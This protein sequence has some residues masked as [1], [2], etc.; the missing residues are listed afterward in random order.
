MG[1][2][3]LSLQTSRIQNALSQG[4]GNRRG[5]NQVGNKGNS[6]DPEGTGQRG[7]GREARRGSYRSVSGQSQGNTDL[8]RHRGAIS[9]ALSPAWVCIRL[10]GESL[11]LLKRCLAKQVEARCE[12]RGHGLR[13]G[14][15]V[16]FMQ[17]ARDVPDMGNSTRDQAS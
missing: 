6:V 17:P 2:R 1:Y 4:H 8:V 11:D 10:I 16:R 7:E 14:M 5:S 12:Q 13:Q 15:H 9:R 3:S